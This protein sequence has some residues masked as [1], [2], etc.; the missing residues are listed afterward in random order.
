MASGTNDLDQ[1]LNELRLA[2]QDP[3]RALFDRVMA[4]GQAA[5]RHLIEMAT[6]EKLLDAALDSPQVWAPLH[7]IELLGELGAAEAME[8]LL[9]LLDRVDDDY[10]AETLPDVFGGM[11]APALEPLRVRLFDRTKDVYSR[12]RTAGSLSKIGQRHPETRSGVVKT[13][14]AR[15]D[16]AE[17][18]TPEDETLNAYVICY[19]LDLEAV[20]AAPAIRRAFDDDRVDTLVVHLDHALEKLGLTLESETS[21]PGEQ[22]GLRLRLRC[23]ACGYEREHLVEKVYYDLATKE[24]K[25]QGKPTPYSEYIIPQRITCPKCGAVDK[26]E[27]SSMAH[28]VLTAELL[29]KVA[30]HKKGERGAEPEEEILQVLRFG[31]SDG[32]VMHPLAT[33]EMYR[34]MVE[35]EPGRADLRVRYA[36][37]LRRLGY[38]EEAIEHYREALRLEPSNLESYLNLGRLALAAGD[39]AEAR[40]MFGQILVQAPS[41][42]VSREDREGYVE[43]ATEELADLAGRSGGLGISTLPAQRFRPEGP[44]S[45]EA[46]ETAGGASSRL[47]RKVGRNEPCPCGGG[48]KY[49]KC[50]GR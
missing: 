22:R 5:V 11:G 30:A 12:V 46:G 47:S 25:E 17:S 42:K 33:R 40:R 23:V 10:L 14:V 29:K 32:R 3:G 18:Q 8:P 34:E 24:L 28:L 44:G 7:A 15:L 39:L 43:A 48:K 9:P 13:L 31:L 36:N 21:W 27:L 16:P 35:A 26:Y 19:L 37:V 41:S 4:H 20:E 45:R 49:K 50:H 1:L 38:R 6:D 2:G